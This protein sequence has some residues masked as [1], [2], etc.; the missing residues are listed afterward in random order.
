[1]ELRYIVSFL[2]IAEE[3]HFGRAAA[4]LHLAQPSL[5]QQLQRLERNVGVRLVNRTSHEV[6]LTA[7]G[8][9]FEIEARKVLVMADQAVEVARKAASGQMG[10]ISIGFNYAPGERILQPTLRCLNAD[11]PDVTTNLWEARSG[12]QLEALSAGKLDVALVYAQSISDEFHSRRV[13]TAELVGIVGPRHP[14]ATREEVLFKELAHEECV[15]FRR[16]QSPAMHDA[17]LAAA[18][19]CGFSLK[20]VEEVDDSSGTGIILSTKSVVGFASTYRARHAPSWGLHRVRLA[21]PVPK[22]GMYAVWRPDPQPVVQ[23]FLNSLT[24]AEP[25]IQSADPDDGPFG[26]SIVAKGTA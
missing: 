26:P 11:Y 9:I 12:P 16:Q 2:A 10:T 15:L 23:A 19:Q 1:V 7:A 18:Q 14:W 25:L 17:I 21:A 20:I 22:V 6:S 3:L 5:S 4:R 13:H 8:R 24:A